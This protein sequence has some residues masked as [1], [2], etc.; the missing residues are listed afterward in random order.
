[1]ATSGLAIPTGLEIGSRHGWNCPMLPWGLR[2]D[3]MPRPV[4]AIP[5]ARF[6]PG[7]ERQGVQEHEAGGHHVDWKLRGK[8]LAQG[9][10][11][12]PNPVYCHHIGHDLRIPSTTAEARHDGKP[13]TAASACRKFASIARIPVL[14]KSPGHLVCWQLRARR[15]RRRELSRKRRVHPQARTR[16]DVSAYGWKDCKPDFV[17]NGR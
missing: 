11:S 6:S 8:R 2:S 15:C 4:A 16:H 14:S 12:E 10:C 1:M 9:R 5:G 17:V 3:R 7:V 13:A